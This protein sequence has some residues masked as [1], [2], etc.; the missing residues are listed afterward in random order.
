MF[1]LSDSGQVM[2]PTWTSVV[3]L[4]A[5]QRRSWQPQRGRFTLWRP[6]HCWHNRMT[7]DMPVSF[8]DIPAI[9]EA[10][11]Q[12][13]EE[14]L[15]T[16]E[17]MAHM[18]AKKRIQ[19]MQQLAAIRQRAKSINV[20]PQR[21]KLFG[22]SRSGWSESTGLKKWGDTLKLIRA[23]EEWLAEQPVAPRESAFLVAVVDFEPSGW[24]VTF[25]DD[26]FDGR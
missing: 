18:R 9:V 4:Q 24:V 21:N 16:G 20:Q 3:C 15:S 12:T 1:S 2:G 13:V 19:G 23:A 7:V 10:A 22:I 8:N 14:R 11:P 17:M 6:S 25:V 5:A 26:A